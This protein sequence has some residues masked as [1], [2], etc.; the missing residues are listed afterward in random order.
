[1]LNLNECK[2]GGGGFVPALSAGS[3]AARCC[4][5]VD[6]GLQCEDYQG[7]A[8]ERRKVCLLF[9]ID[10]ERV[11]VD[12][13]EKP[14]MMSITLTFSIHEKAALR[15][16]LASWRGRDFT[17]AELADF[18]LKNILGAGCL[19]S[20]S[21]GVSSKGYT[22]AKISAIAPPLKGG[23]IPPTS[24]EFL[25]DLDDDKTFNAFKEIPAWLQEKINAGLTV[26]RRGVKFAVASDGLV[27]Q[28]SLAADI[29][30]D[31]FEEIIGEGKGGLPF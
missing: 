15:K 1:M 27:V 30:T 12:G 11:E 17:Q 28:R 9:E 20:V 3:Y 31:D 10:G 25:F 22:F 21:N 29:N 8:A 19:L 5:V 4:G 23:D 18:H 14:R 6:I 7:V 13:E 16:H 2:Q 26:M 24:R